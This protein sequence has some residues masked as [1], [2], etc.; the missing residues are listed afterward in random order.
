MRRARIVFL[1][2]C[3][4]PAS[5]AAGVDRPLTALPYTAGLNPEFMDRKVDPCTDFY[6]YACNGWI[7]KNPIPPDQPSWHVYRKMGDENRQFLW[8]ILEEAAAKGQGRTPAEARAGDYFAA[9]MDE[10]AVEAAG[11][12][13]LR[14][15]L[16]AIDALRSPRQIAALFGR[17]HPTLGSELVFGLGAEQ[18]SRNAERVIATVTAGGL[19]LPDRDYYLSDEPRMQEAR[20][21]YQE[22]VQRLLFLSGEGEETSRAGAERVLALETALARATL[23]EVD[24][25]D[26]YKVYHRMTPSQLGVLM[27][28]FDWDGYLQAVGAR[29]ARFINVT[30]PVFFLEVEARLESEPLQVWKDYLRARLADA[31]A[32]Y[33][34]RAFQRAEFEFRGAYLRGV[35]EEKVRWKKCIAW[36]DRDLGEALGRMF[37]SRVFPK[38][39]KAQVEDMTRRIEAAMAERIRQSTWMSE[40]T[41]R[42]ALAKL[43]TMRNKIGYPA[44]WRDYGRLELRRADFLGNVERASRFESARQMSKIGKPVDRGEWDMSP[45]TV[46]AY[47]DAHLNDINFPAG[48]LLPPLWDPRL[49]LAPGYGNTGGT[50]GHELT[51]G[52]DDEGRQFDGQG[53][54]R[55]WWLP[56]DAE[57]FRKRAQCIIDQYGQYPVVDDIHIN[58]RLSVGED[59]AD[60]GGELLAWM[61]W[62]D[63]TRGQTLEPRDGLTPEQRFFVG[64]AQ[65]ACENETDESKRV[66]AKTDP[67]SPGRWRINGVVANMPQFRE[68][69]SC[70]VGS[71]MA[72]EKT[73]EVW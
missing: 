43:S 29:S 47:Y 65:W 48:V 23:S 50:I 22:Y 53:N 24:R 49:D 52:F 34:S 68:A 35:K 45:P 58:S 16:A 71:P 55:D 44:R 64:M 36:V 67:H 19:G 3:L 57:A 46:N 62:K 25:R 12:A 4:G 41:R 60:L 30:E 51:H 72:P 2:L 42:A 26:P 15:E 32:P 33:L 10:T 18:D 73:C 38:E 11:D 40:A 31:R 28:H 14:R 5:R 8:G 69:F 27:P 37:V 7:E 1:A 63:A 54:L 70:P 9:C 66:H 20:T 59:I 61:A 56:A 13:P 39:V 17:L 21:H 6:A